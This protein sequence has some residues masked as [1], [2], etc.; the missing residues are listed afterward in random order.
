MNK[1]VLALFVFAAA[2]FSSCKKCVTCTY[3]TGDTITKCSNEEGEN[4]QTVD[5][6]RSGSLAL[7][8]D[9]IDD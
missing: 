2:G 9:C 5:T 8:A 6:W 7:G 1:L 4:K 3:N